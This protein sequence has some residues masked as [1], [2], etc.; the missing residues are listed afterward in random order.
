MWFHWPWEDS[1]IYWAW[2]CSVWVLCSSARYKDKSV[3]MSCT[4][5]SVSA[6][7]YHRPTEVC[8][9]M[10]LPCVHP[11]WLSAGTGNVGE[12]RHGERYLICISLPDSFSFLFHEAF[13][14]PLDWQTREVR[15]LLEANIWC[16]N[17]YLN[18]TLFPW[19]PDLSHW[20]WDFSV[21]SYTQLV[22]CN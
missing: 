18:T 4:Y 2:F 12:I 8:I 11:A 16:Q 13:S 20:R 22:G 10:V 6:L 19:L 9:G 5:W 1:S 21:Q 17:L 15:E 7:T 3:K 14:W